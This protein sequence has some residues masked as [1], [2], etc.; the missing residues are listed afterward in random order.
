[1][2]II[3]LLVFGVLIGNFATTILYR[4]PRN[5]SIASTD[6]K[7][8]IYPF[9]SICLHSLRFYEYLPVLSWFSTW[10]KCN[11]CNQPIA[12]SY[13]LLEIL[14]ATG[15]I[16]I[17]FVTKQ[18]L[19]YFFLYFC[20]FVLSLLNILIYFEHNFISK[21]I[22][23]AIIILGMIFRT[24]EDQEIFTWLLYL[25]LSF[26]LGL[27]IIRTNL[28]DHNIIQIITP[29]SLWCENYALLVLISILYFLYLIKIKRIFYPI[30]LCAVFLVSLVFFVT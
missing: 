10:G 13:I 21:Y 5:I 28:I 8:T 17:Y 9:C 26:I 4:L 24:L 23:L 12:K 3:I 7:T 19:E 29:A 11:Y 6:L 27:Y 20:F 25:S 16:F 22:T 15:S 2:Q 30:S 18:N 14:C 1:M